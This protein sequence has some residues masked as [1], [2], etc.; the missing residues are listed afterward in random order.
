[1][2]VFVGSSA[3]WNGEVCMSSY[4]SSK[5]ALEGEILIHLRWYLRKAKLTE[6]LGM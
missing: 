2:L 4:A 1:M 6:R 5:F 3:G